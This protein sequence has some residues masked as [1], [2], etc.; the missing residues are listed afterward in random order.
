M[1]ARSVT[2][3]RLAGALR[4]GDAFEHAPGTDSVAEFS[5]RALSFLLS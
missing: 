5:G 1:R 2:F 4:I 3:R